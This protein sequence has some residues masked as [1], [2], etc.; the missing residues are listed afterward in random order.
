VHNDVELTFYADAT[1]AELIRRDD[2]WDVWFVGRSPFVAT[3]DAIRHDTVVRAVDGT[4]TDD[5]VIDFIEARLIAA[6]YRMCGRKRVRGTI[7]AWDL[8]TS[9]P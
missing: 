8:A 5:G 1:S 9:A 4:I 6:G 3:F 2:H 7:A